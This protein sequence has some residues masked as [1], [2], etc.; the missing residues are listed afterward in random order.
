L[1]PVHKSTDFCPPVPLVSGSETPFL[2]EGF[3]LLDRYELQDDL[4]ETLE[5]TEHHRHL[6]PRLALCHRTFR[7]W[8]CEH[9]HDWAEAENSCSLRICPHDQRR[10]SLVMAARVEKFLGGRTDGLRYAVLAERNST[11]LAEGIASLWAAWSRLRRSVRWKRKVAGCVVVMEVTRNREE[12]TWHPHLNVLMEG[13]YFPF[14][15][16]NQAWV[17]ATEGRGQTSFIRA[18]D[19]GT[20]RELIKYIT[21]LADLLGDAPA[22][23]EF[24][25]AIKGQRLLRTY[26]TFFGLKI[27]DDGQPDAGCCPDCGPEMHVA[28][29]KLG[30]VSPW[31]LSLDFEGVLRVSAAASS[32]DRFREAIQFP[33]ALEPLPRKRPTPVLIRHWDQLH[34]KFAATSRRKGEVN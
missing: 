29:V 27:D 34:E 22:L 23:D 3:R 30:P 15:E 7:H 25:T 9:D 18:A 26:G 33:P 11:D 19:A 17:K 32:S 6:V 20:V 2:D 8:R 5:K 12:G 4:I 10:R 21:K 16:L 13:E 31:Q 1:I 14:E 28:V 24:L